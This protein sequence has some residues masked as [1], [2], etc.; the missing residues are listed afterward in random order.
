MPRRPFSCWKS[1][2]GLSRAVMY[3]PRC[4]PP[5]TVLA[6]GTTAMK[7]AEAQS[8]LAPLQ[9]EFARRYYR[10]C[11]AESQRELEADFPAI[12][13]MQSHVS[14]LFLEFVES[15]SRN[16]IRDLMVGGLK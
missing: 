15:C 7:C 4:D 10:W 9:D 3:L 5:D 11:L 2:P 1:N 8:L 14:F 6:L 12:R 16:E 13:A